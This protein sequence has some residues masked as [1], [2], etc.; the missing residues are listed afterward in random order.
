[1]I[2]SSALTFNYLFVYEP[3]VEVNAMCYVLTKGR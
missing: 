1:M 2:T 3:Q